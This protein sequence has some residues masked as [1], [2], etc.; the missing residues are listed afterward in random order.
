MK[1]RK[2]L[3]TSALPYANGPIH[4]GHLVEY[5]QTD[6][7][8]RFHKM[9]GHE[10]YYICASDAHGT[11]IML[12]AEKEGISPETLVTKTREEHLEDFSRFSIEF[13][14][15]YTT[16]SDENK[17]V[18]E[19]IYRSLLDQ[20]HIKKRLV[21]QFFDPV[22]NMFLP[23]RFIRGNCPSCGTPDQY[24]D[25]CEKC[26]ST[27]SPLDLIDPR[28]VLTSSPPEVKESEH[29]FF[30]LSSFTDILLN[31]T[32]DAD[33]H[34]SVRN[35][36]EE[37]FAIGLKD[38]DISRDEPYFGFKIPDNPGKYFYV[39][40][41]APIGYLGSFKNFCEKEGMNFDF[42]VRESADLEMFHF[43]GKD[44]MYF[45]TLFWPAILNASGFK[46]PSSVFV[47]GFL[48]VNGQKMS[49]SRGTFITAKHY[50]ENLDPEHLRYYF[51]AKISSSIE[52]IDLSLEDY[53]FRV[54]ADLVGKFVN[55]GSRCA[56]FLEK[57][58]AGR[59][60]GSVENLEL[61][62]KF[63]YS[64]GVISECYEK[65]EYR[66]VIRVVMALADDANKYIDE[67]KPWKIAKDKSKSAELHDVVT[68][69]ILMF[70]L[71][72]IF[73]KPV[74]PELVGK[75]EKFLNESNLLFSHIYNVPL[76]KKI[77][78]FGRLTDRIVQ[79]NVDNLH[80]K[81]KEGNM[82]KEE[83]DSE[84][85]ISIEDFKKIDLRVATIIAA[86]EVEESDKLL[87]LELDLDDRTSTVFAGIK[88][89]YDVS[90]LINRRVICVANLKPRKMRF[91]TSE[92]M[93]LAASGGQERLFLLEPDDGAE[94]GMIVS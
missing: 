49:K 21:Q 88:G 72:A 9:C 57:D 44:I 87:E 26:G 22:K 34:P 32:N 51:A 89:K 6:I 7:W 84:Q 74:L 73:L 14:N 27:Y 77:N 40:L 62:E 93:I 24:G 20:G 35:K 12:K 56:G 71:L 55:I 17:H 65:R 8:V 78:K 83:K 91:G 63:Q 37:W 54:N 28:S 43:V 2:I 18:V 16:H 41:D 76:N 13:D 60:S 31:W 53:T 81:P 61:L 50:L 80:V 11:P 75:V 70:R 19:Q 86:K 58:F 90:E 4:I 46:L 66:K 47:H 3:V 59:L 39:W 10:C 52:D 69:G 5:I 42:L 23:D 79:E 30:S 15:F 45:H 68:Q 64:F 1:N 82:Q 38:W 85:Y 36:L 33:L 67:K 29:L 94:A 92:G 25:S 48:T